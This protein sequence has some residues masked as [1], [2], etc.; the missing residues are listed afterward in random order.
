MYDGVFDL[1][2]LYQ[3]HPQARAREPR[4]MSGAAAGRSSFE[5]LASQAPQDDGAGRVRSFQF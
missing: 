4:R 2:N 1:T 5:M 3:R